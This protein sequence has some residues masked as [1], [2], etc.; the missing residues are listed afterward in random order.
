[1]NPAAVRGRIDPP[2]C[3]PGETLAFH[4]WAQ[5]M[6]PSAQGRC[7]GRCHHDMLP[8][9][10][11]WCRGLPDLPERPDVRVDDEP[12]WVKWFP[13]ERRDE[14]GRCGEPIAPDALIRLTDEGVIGKTC[15]GS[16]A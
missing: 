13:A 9:Q 12:R 2:A 6:I 15:C 5:S 8:G 1:M 10:C 3:Y 16:A 4:R 14:C 7:T 11:S